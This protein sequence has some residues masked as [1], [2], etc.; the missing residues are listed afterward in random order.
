MSVREDANVRMHGSLHNGAK[1]AVEWT[2]ADS[3]ESKTEKDRWGRR[4]KERSLVKT[5]GRTFLHFAG[6]SIRLA[7]HRSSGMG[8]WIESAAYLEIESRRLGP[9]VDVTQ[10]VGAVSAHLDTQILPVPGISRLLLQ[11]DS[12][13][14]RARRGRKAEEEEATKQA[15]ESRSEGG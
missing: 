5:G 12:R 15:G 14:P 10:N 13:D 4:E 1:E 7:R 6:V 11:T 8:P 3:Y 2:E 9:E